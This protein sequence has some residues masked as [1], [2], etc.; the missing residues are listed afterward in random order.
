VEN[1]VENADDMLF[2]RVLN[3]QYHLLHSLL[4]DK[5][6]H[7]YDLQHRRHKR[8][9]SHNDDQRNFVPG[10]IHK[11]LLNIFSYLIPSTELSEGVNKS[12]LFSFSLFIIKNTLYCAAGKWILEHSDH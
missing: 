12:P 4:P 8:I 3:N 2:R 10:Q 1:L 11:Q 6:S 5:N 7:G 9:L